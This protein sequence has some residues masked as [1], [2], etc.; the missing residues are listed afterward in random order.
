MEIAYLMLSLLLATFGFRLWY[1]L[2]PSLR[3]PK[4]YQ[5]QYDIN[6]SY[7]YRIIRRRLAGFIL[8]G[9][10]PYWLIFHKKVLGEVS[11]ADLGFSFSWNADVSFWVAVLIPVGLFF[12]WR[13]FRYRSTLVNYPEIRLTI[14]TPMML[15]VSA[16]CW[17]LF[18]V[19][20]EFLFRGLV[21]HSLVQAGEGVYAT[22][23]LQ[24]WGPI[25]IATGLYAMIHYFKNDRVS[26]VC[27]IYGLGLGYVTLKTGSLLP[28]IILH[29]T[30]GFFTEWFA[31]WRHP[32]IKV[33]RKLYQ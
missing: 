26:W 20:M 11:L 5:I 17:V 13:N 24:L 27:I 31:I 30:S 7:F 18:L 16:I 2:S 1:F 14:W 22:P 29:I 6:T 4:S 28:T 12:T 10:L 15:V 23:W 8:Y 19:G 25:V 3:L 33:Q 32:E 21:L 9:A